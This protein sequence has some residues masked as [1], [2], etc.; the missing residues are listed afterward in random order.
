MGEEQSFLF[1]ICD[2]HLN[3]AGCKDIGSLL[4]V[5]LVF[6]GLHSFELVL[7][8]TYLFCTNVFANISKLGDFDIGAISS[9]F[10]TISRICLLV[11]IRRIGN[12]HEVPWSN[13][14]LERYVISNIYL[15]MTVWIISGFTANQLAKAMV[16]AGTGANLFEK[17]RIF[18]KEVDPTVALKCFRLLVLVINVI[19]FTL[20]AVSVVTGTREMFTIMRRGPYVWIGM[21]SG[22]ISPSILYFFGRTV[23]KS[24]RSNKKKIDRNNQSVI[25]W[26]EKFVQLVI[27]FAYWPTFIACFLYIYVNENLPSNSNLIVVKIITEFVQWFGPTLCIVVLIYRM[28]NQSRKRAVSHT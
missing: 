6:I 13:A 1:T 26:L 19:L 11:N 16:F 22:I 24:L 3:Y 14:D 27:I 10:F 21:L 17:L 18:G 7:C 2:F 23:I 25:N 12:I 4:M 5:D 28:I 8:L 9:T 20:F 15:E